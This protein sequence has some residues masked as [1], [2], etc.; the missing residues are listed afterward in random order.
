MIIDGTFN[1]NALRLPL[2]AAVGVSNSGATFPLAFS[3]CPSESED[4]FGFFFDSMK[5]MV[6]LKGAKIVSGVNTSLPKVV[7]GDQAAG[8]ISALPKYLSSAQLQH[9]DWHAVEAMKRRFRKGGYT[10]DQIDGTD[11]VSGLAELA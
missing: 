6:F 2:L 1:T 7:L 4:A 9:C 5:E 8:L 10:S 3:Y 11:E